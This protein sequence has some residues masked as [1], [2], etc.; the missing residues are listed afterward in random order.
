VSTAAPSGLSLRELQLWFQE[1]LAGPNAR[2]VRPPAVRADAE[3]VV[4][5]SDRLTAPQ[6]LTIYTEMYFLRLFD[7]MGEDFPTAR[8]LLGEAE[9]SE[10]VRGYL[11][12]HPSRSWTLNNLGARFAAYLAGRDDLARHALLADVARIERAMTEVFDAPNG[13]VLSATAFAAVPA[14]QWGQA[15]LQLQRACVLMAFDHPVTPIL[16]AVRHGEPLPPLEPAPH[17]VVVYR[18]DGRSWRRPLTEPMFAALGA[19]AAG[20]P[21]PAALEAAAAVWPASDEELE[22]AVFAWFREW[23]A[24][25]LFAT[26]CI[27]ASGPAQNG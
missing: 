13:P 23:V 1:Q 14:E 5:P 12:A 20:K 26:V 8:E 19:L 21:V 7:V 27:P 22:Q 3:R 10:V 2:P 18:K 15:V 25:E 24:E 17:W 9:W 4:K 16:N 6:R 11:T